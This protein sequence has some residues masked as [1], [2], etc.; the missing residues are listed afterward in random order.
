[1][2]D[3]EEVINA[4]ARNLIMNMPAIKMSEPINTVE[5]RRNLV[6]LFIHKHGYFPVKYQK[7]VTKAIF[8]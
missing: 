8:T 3:R 1:M 6:F 5:V 2:T 4:Y 7:A